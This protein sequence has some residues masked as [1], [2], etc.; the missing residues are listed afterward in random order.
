MKLN[1]SFPSRHGLAALA[2][3]AFCSSAIALPALTHS[4]P[5]HAESEPG[6]TCPTL[7]SVYQVPTGDET[8][9][10]VGWTAPPGAEYTHFTGDLM[11]PNEPIDGAGAARTYT[12]TNINPQAR[13]DI[14]IAAWCANGQYSLNSIVINEDGTGFDEELQ[15]AATAEANGNGTEPA[16]TSEN[17]PTPGTPEMN[18]TETTP[19]ADNP[20]AAG[21]GG[22]KSAASSKSSLVDSGSNNVPVAIAAGILVLAGGLVLALKA[23]RRTAR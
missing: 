16:S 1:W 20:P 11:N 2:F 12:I 21:S 5:A 14:T 7:E 15:N 9:V 13:I 17:E 8:V 4:V 10:T 18:V 22:G 23:H 19:H 6:W 3:G